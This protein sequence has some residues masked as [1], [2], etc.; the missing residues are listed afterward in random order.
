MLLDHH[1]ALQY[2]S[3][4]LSLVPCSAKTKRPDPSLLPRDE[5]DKPVW[6]PYQEHPPTAE[7]VKGWFSRGCKSVAGIGG[8]VSGGLLIIDFDVAR[9]FDTWREQVGTL[10]DGLPVQRTGRKVADTRCGCVAPAGPKQSWLGCRTKRKT[11]DEGGNRNER[12]RWLC[13]GPR[14]PSSIGRRYE[15]LAGDFANIPTVPQAVADALLA[16]AESW[17]KRRSH[18]NSWKQKRKRQPP[19]RSIAMKA[20]GRAVSSTPTMSGRRSAK[21]WIAM[22]T[23]AWASVTSGPEARAEALL[24]GMAVPPQQQ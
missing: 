1:L 22:D 20:T 13:R 9:F 21:R 7:V 5:N 18:G 12:R 16:A 8:R 24:C 19:R 6:G 10:A 4:G 2:L 3:G 17:T 14:F 23:P 11:A 15:A